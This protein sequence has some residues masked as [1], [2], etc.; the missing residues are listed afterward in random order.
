MQGELLRLG[1][2]ATTHLES[3]RSD[4]IAFSKIGEE[5]SKMFTRE[6]QHLL[7]TGRRVSPEVLRKNGARVRMAV[8][9]AVRKSSSGQKATN[10]N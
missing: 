7:R 3:V 4:A 10:S 1:R 5:T 9:G 8:R 6:E 2:E